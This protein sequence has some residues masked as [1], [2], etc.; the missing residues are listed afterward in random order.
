M[1]WAILLIFVHI[2]VCILYFNKQIKQRSLKSWCVEISKVEEG[3]EGEGEEVEGKE[4]KM[5]YKI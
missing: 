2:V 3:R 5:T 4:A 1:H